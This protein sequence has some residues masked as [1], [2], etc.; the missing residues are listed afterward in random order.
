MKNPR[1]PDTLQF[2][3]ISAATAFSA[4]PFFNNFRIFN[5][6]EYSDPPAGTI[7]SILGWFDLAPHSGANNTDFLLPE[8]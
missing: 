1:V 8:H 6:R 5:N 2:G 7:V 3:A 4:S